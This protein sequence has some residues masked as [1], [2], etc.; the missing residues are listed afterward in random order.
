MRRFEA[1]SQGRKW[2]V[3]GLAGVAALVA[4]LQVA[5]A[6]QDAGEQAADSI[7]A[8]TILPAD[9]VDLVLEREVFDYPNYG[10]RNPFRPLTGE[11]MGPRFEDLLLTGVLVSL[12]RTRSIA[13][14]GE[15]P[16]GSATTETPE[17]YTRLREGDVIGNTRIIEIRDRWVTVQVEEFGEYDLRTLELVRTAPQP[18]PGREPTPVPAA[19]P[20]EAPED[21]GAEGATPAQTPPVQGMRPDSPNGNG[22]R[23]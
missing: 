13:T 9:S 2:V 19:P 11:D 6:L 16:P 7:T 22:G 8:V 5:A 17:R 18:V 15:R 3:G 12:D 23:S 4:A 14:I 10:R 20:A 21:A 1:R